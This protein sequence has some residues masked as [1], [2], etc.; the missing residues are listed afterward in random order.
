LAASSLKTAALGPPDSPDRDPFVMSSRGGATMRA[1][2]RGQIIL[3]V[4]FA[5]IAA[6]AAAARGTVEVVVT[7]KQPSLAY[8]AGHDRM[9]ASMTMSKG[10][11]DLRS[12]SSLS[13]IDLLHSEQDA[14]AARIA[15]AIPGAYVHWRYAITLNG[16]A[17]VVPAGKVTALAHVAGV[18]KVWSSVTYHSSLDRTPQLIGAPTLWGPMLATAGQGM[19]IAVIDE[20]VDQTHPFLSPPVSPCRPGSRRVTRRSRPRR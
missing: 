4:L 17:V 2:R 8:A 11:V 20:G 18:A 14:V 1:L 12:P 5:L 3:A 15:S 19:K 6:P 9:L 16:L 13:Y 7:L 10:R